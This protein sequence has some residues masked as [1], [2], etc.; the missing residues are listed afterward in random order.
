MRKNTITVIV[1]P[2]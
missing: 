2:L 1:F